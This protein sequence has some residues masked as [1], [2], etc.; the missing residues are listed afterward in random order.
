M[1]LSISGVVLLGV[2]VFFFLK[3]DGLKM[4]HAIVCAL[5]GFY[6]STTTLAPSIRAT[7]TSFANLISG[8]RF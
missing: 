3:K 5:F 2:I 6:L 7:G 8:F 1:V 4:T